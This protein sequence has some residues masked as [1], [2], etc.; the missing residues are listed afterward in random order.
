MS[1]RQQS[2]MDGDFQG[3]EGAEEKDILSESWLICRK[4]VWR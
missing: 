3:N 4:Q 1:Q 2:T